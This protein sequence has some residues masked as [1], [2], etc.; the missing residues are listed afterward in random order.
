MVVAKKF[1]KPLTPEQAL[2]AAR[3]CWRNARDLLADATVLLE[4]HRYPRTIFL[5]GTA[6]EELGKMTMLLSTV[7][8]GE[9]FDWKAFWQD[10]RKHPSKF[11]SEAV[12]AAMSYGPETADEIL[13]LLG[14]REATLYVDYYFGKEALLEPGVLGF[15][16]AKDYLTT[17]KVVFEDYRWV[18]DRPDAE[19]LTPPELR[20]F[21]PNDP[22]QETQRVLHGINRLNQWATS[23]GWQPLGIAMPRLT[24]PP[25]S[26]APL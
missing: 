21:D 25:S 1:N 8:A 3:A 6:V 22:D 17:A 11:A 4:N 13:G 2:A 7:G 18:R 14:F 20:I 12:G 5:A 26:T 15:G 10:F 9:L 24:E 19:F 16:L 23:H